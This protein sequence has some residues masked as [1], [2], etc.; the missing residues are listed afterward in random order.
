[1]SAVCRAARAS[2]AYVIDDAAQAL[3][4]TRSGKPAG[5]FG[6]VGIYSL[7]RG[8]SAGSVAGGLLVTDSDEIAATVQSEL[9]VLGESG[10]TSGGASLFKMLSYSLLLHP[11]LFW[12]PNSLPFLKL[13]TTE[14]EPSFATAQMD[15]LSMALLPSLLGDL[16]GLNQVRRT[17]AEKITGAL[18]GSRNFE[19]PSRGTSGQ[20]TFVRLPVVARNRATR[21]EAIAQLRSAGIGATAF[22]PSAICDISGVEKHIPQSGFHC[23]RAEELSRRLLTLPVHPFAQ[24][25][26]I[27]RMVDILTIL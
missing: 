1:M 5:T 22:Y 7:G 25:K 2:D 10:A 26:D 8:K 15:P 27:E 19:F 3:G 23:V 12:I 24:P 21:D 16:D 14:F 13:G 18:R 6:D 11:R 17:N 20:P 4:S 9:R